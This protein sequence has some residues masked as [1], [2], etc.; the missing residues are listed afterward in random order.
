[1]DQ[2]YYK[3]HNLKKKKMYEISVGTYYD[4]EGYINVD[5]VNKDLNSKIKSFTEELKQ[6]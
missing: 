1:M 3:I 2:L 5:A 4:S 6:E